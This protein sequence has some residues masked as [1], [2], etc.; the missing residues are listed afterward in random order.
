M[1]EIVSSTVCLTELHVSVYN[2]KNGN[3]WRFRI[4]LSFER[5]FDWL[6]SALKSF[7][8]LNIKAAVIVTERETIF[9]M[10]IST[11]KYI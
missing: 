5:I 9:E 3:V 4:F 10:M 6:C 8:E 2:T 11:G 7:F 1:P